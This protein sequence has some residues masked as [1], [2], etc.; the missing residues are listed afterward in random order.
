MGAPNADNVRRTSSGGVR[1][2]PIGTTAPA[3]LV[4]AY[5]AGWL[6]LGWLSEDGITETPNQDVT[7]FKGLGGVTVRKVI[8]S[9]E[10]T[11]QFTIIERNGPTWDLYYPGSTRTT[12]AGITTLIVK[13]PVADPR[14]FAFDVLDGA[15]NHTR[16]EVP[17]GE[18]SERGELVFKSDE[19]EA[20]QFTMTCYPAADGETYRKITNDAAV[21]VPAP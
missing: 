6:E 13:S 3:D 10:T 18:I 7:E 2:A 17:K 21:A 5:A 4:T 8:S 1:V 11:F 20:Y 14:A 12:A 16:I 15:A 19:M 9:S